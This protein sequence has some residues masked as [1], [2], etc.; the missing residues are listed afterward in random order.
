MSELNGVRIKRTSL[1]RGLT[2]STVLG[3]AWCTEL[4]RDEFRKCDFTTVRPVLLR[5]NTSTQNFHCCDALPQGKLC[6][7]PTPWL[8]CCIYK[9]VGASYMRQNTALATRDGSNSW[10][11]AALPRQKPHHELACWWGHGQ[12]HNMLTLTVPNWLRGVFTH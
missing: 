5:S 4:A 2:C 6:I 1:N 12:W 10:C 7:Y 9:M 8:Y 11:V 3:S